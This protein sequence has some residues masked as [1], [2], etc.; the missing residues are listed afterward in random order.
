MFLDF[1]H[2]LLRGKTYILRADK[3]QKVLRVLDPDLKP[4]T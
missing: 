1:R 2:G 3:L 4:F